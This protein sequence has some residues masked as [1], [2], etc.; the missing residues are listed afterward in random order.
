M[1]SKFEY[2][3]E[4]QAGVS[5]FGSTEQHRVLTAASVSEFRKSALTCYPVLYN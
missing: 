2:K 1:L 3:V 5:T 4:R